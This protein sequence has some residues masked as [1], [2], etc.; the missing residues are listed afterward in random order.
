MRVDRITEVGKEMEIESKMKYAGMC[1]KNSVANS[2][3]DDGDSD[4]IAG[5][6]LEAYDRFAGE[7]TVINVEHTAAAQMSKYTLHSIFY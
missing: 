2:L 7:S 1:G 5:E 3:G 6:D 4:Y